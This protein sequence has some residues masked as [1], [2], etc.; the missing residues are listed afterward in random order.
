MSRGSRFSPLERAIIAAL[1]LYGVYVMVS[2]LISVPPGEDELAWHQGTVLEKKLGYASKV[3]EATWRVSGLTREFRHRRSMPA[4]EAVV[5]GMP[6]GAEVEVLVEEGT[7][8]AWHVWGLR[9][10]GQVVITEADMRAWHR[11]QHLI[12]YI[13]LGAIALLVVL[14]GFGMWLHHRRKA[15]RPAAP[16]EAA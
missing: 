15:R 1:C 4:Y 9:V 2:D 3:R 11:Q 13:T 6:V 10:E 7:D 12:G 14:A 8:P 5:E 16:V